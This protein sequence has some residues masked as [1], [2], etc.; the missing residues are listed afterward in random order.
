[1]LHPWEIIGAIQISLYTIIT[2]VSIYPAL[3]LI[4][5]KSSFKWFYIR[6]SI[7]LLTKI[8]GGALLIS[9]THDYT[10]VNMA[11][12]TSVFNTIALGLISVLLAFCVRY[13][14]TYKMT[15]ENLK[16]S[17][18][19]KYKHGVILSLFTAD[20]TKSRSWEILAEKL[21]IVVMIV[22]IVGNCSM[23]DDRET[24]KKLQEAGSILFLVVLLVIICLIIHKVIKAK[25][26]QSD[27]EY[28]FILI[29]LFICGIMSPFILVRMIYSIC[30]AFAFKVDGTYTTDVSKYTFLFG[31]W[32]YYAFLGFLE[33]CICAGLYSMMSW[34]VFIGERRL[35]K[36]EDVQQ[37]K[38]A[39]LD[40][41]SEV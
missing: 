21:L 17:S 8:I 28:K 25:K 29:V 36:D 5:S 30:S 19:S 16:S 37:N 6:Y 23:S 38:S 20:Y 11:I 10:N 3:K 18:K 12:A 2:L 15:H 7:L 1:M 35:I 24:S 41:N 26:R 34:V 22:N 14:D 39:V 13:V 9:Y 40:S 27:K 33:E 31:D 32:K 4:K